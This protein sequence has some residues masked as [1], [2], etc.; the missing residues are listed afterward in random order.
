LPAY[1]ALAGAFVLASTSETWGLVVNEAM[2]CGLPVLVSK[3]CG[4]AQDLVADGRNGFTF[5][6]LD[7]QALT[8]LMLRMAS[9]GLD[10]AAMS[11]ASREIIARWTP[12]LW[13]NNLRLAS[14]AASSAPRPKFS[15]ADRLLLRLLIQR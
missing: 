11:R 6:P 13:A 8:R 4:C 7:V 2:A 5:D 9:P 1:Y 14:A 3:R 12:S 15:A 10:L